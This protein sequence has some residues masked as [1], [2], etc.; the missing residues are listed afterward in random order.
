ME[1]WT[2]DPITKLYGKT[3][4]TWNF[5]VGESSITDNFMAPIYI[6]YGGIPVVGWGAF[7]IALPSLFILS[8]PIWFIGLLFIALIIWKQSFKL[9]KKEFMNGLSEI[10]RRITFKKKKGGKKDV[11]KTKTKKLTG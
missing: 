10:K 1:L 11:K 7:S 2:F 5:N 4:V 9:A 3:L 8:S 6:T